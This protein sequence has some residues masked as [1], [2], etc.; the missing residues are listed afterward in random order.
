V[1]DVTLHDFGRP[2]LD[3]L[4]NRGIE[5]EAEG[6]NGGVEAAPAAP[7]GNGYIYSLSAQDFP[8]AKRCRALDAA[9]AYDKCDAL[10][11]LRHSIP[12]DR[13]L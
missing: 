13:R 12:L 3:R 5:V 1:L 2:Q 4:V 7:D 9:G 11:V 8:E 6:D 10:P